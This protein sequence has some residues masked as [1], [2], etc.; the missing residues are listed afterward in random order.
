MD[1]PYAKVGLSATDVAWPY[2]SP[3]TITILYYQCT[4][5]LYK[6]DMNKLVFARGQYWGTTTAT[7]TTIATKTS[8]KNGA[9]ICIAGPGLCLFP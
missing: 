3:T 1:F 8:F 9:T 7:R 5:Y 2:P 4:F 6:F